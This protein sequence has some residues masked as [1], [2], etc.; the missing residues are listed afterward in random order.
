MAPWLGPHRRD[1][2]RT[3]VAMTDEVKA[4]ELGGDGGKSETAGSDRLFTHYSSN[5]P[6]AA[7][8]PDA[9]G[10]LTDDEIKELAIALIRS[11]GPSGE[12]EIMKVATWAHRVRVDSTLLQGVLSGSLLV[13]TRTDPRD[14]TFRL[15]AAGEARARAARQWV[16]ADR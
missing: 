1:E 11:R 10:G 16:A 12:D 6:S 2:G 15:S 9:H 7:S 3:E 13:D 4:A 8:R 5:E 14:L